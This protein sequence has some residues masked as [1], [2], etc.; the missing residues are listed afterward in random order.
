MIGRYGIPVL[1][2]LLL[3][4]L[5]VGAELRQWT[6]ENGVKH[7]SNKKKLPEGASV[8]RSFEEKESHPGE[9]RPDRKT[10]PATRSKPR[11]NQAYQSRS[12]PDR[13]TILKEIR[14]REAKQRDLFDRIYTKRRY[15]KRHGKQDI[16]RIRRLNAEIDTLEK[17][18]PDPTGIEQLKKERAAA[19][20]R[21][22]N[23]NLRTRK[24]VG[25]DVQE[26]QKIETEIAELQKSL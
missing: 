19:K 22:F 14:I 11:T 25:V 15:V 20:G 13:A 26:Y 10:T 3:T 5:P 6:N 4:V 7:F 9:R 24:G 23:E 17:S 8:E 12:K 18:G 16:D 21:L 1:F 2:T